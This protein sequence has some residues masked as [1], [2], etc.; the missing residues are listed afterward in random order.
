M[1]H[2]A[3]LR[4]S[5]HHGFLT[6]KPLEQFTMPYLQT[7]PKHRTLEPWGSEVMTLPI[8]TQPHSDVMSSPQTRGGHAKRQCHFLQGEPPPF[9]PQ[10]PSSPWRRGAQKQ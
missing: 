7:E 5:L 10:V 4:R 9:V 8:C 2:L 3:S 6:R 1:V